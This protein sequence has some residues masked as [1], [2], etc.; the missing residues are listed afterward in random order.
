MYKVISQNRQIVRKCNV[1]TT[2]NSRKTSLISL[3][4]NKIHLKTLIH[5]SKNVTK[6]Y[7]ALWHFWYFWSILTWNFQKGPFCRMKK[8]SSTMLP[9]KCHSA[10]YFCKKNMDVSKALRISLSLS[11]SLYIYI[12]MISSAVH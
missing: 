6:K 2:R 4:S 8:Y 5:S 11:L 7:I 9:K 10:R 12:Y 3:K 1:K